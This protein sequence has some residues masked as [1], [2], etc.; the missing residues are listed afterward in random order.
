MIHHHL[1]DEMI[2]AYAAG[3]LSV[4]HALVVASHLEIC[5]HCAARLADAEAIGGAMLDDCDESAVSDDLFATMM[6]SLDDPDMEYTE[7]S[8]PADRS[9]VKT[10]GK[11]HVPALLASVIGDDFD[12]I[13]WRTAG[14]G[15][16]QFVLP[17]EGTEGETV[18]LLKLSPG[19]VTPE[20]SH[21]GSEMTLVL[22]GSF[23]DDT[24]RYRVGDI[25]DADDDVHHQPIADTDEECICL[26]VTDAPLEFKG[27]ITRLLQPIIGI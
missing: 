1:N 8:V 4:G 21:H 12:A 3:A 20:H 15:I 22:K 24:G 14:P 17:L 23:S 16:K 9:M 7:A 11:V 13:R 2:L 19:F 6:R 26:A 27:V 5:P 18:R 10:A 25:Q